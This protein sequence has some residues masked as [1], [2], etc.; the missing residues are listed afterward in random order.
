VG[1]ERKHGRKGEMRKREW[2]KVEDK[3]RENKKE[4]KK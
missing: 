1:E 2:E 4:R 3:N